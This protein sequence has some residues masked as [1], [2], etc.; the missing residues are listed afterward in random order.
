M[1]HRTTLA[2]L[3]FTVPA[4]AAAGALSRYTLRTTETRW[5]IAAFAALAAGVELTARLSG[6]GRESAL[7]G[8]L[9]AA[10][11]ALLIVSVKFQLEPEARKA[12]GARLRHAAKTVLRVASDRSGADGTG[13]IP[14]APENRTTP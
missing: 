4:F 5:Q 10:A 1:Q 12:D 6:P 8:T 14:R 9:N 7:R 3:A 11:A 2:T 13:P